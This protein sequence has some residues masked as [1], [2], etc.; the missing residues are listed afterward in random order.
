M[1]A[2]VLCG[3][4]DGAAVRYLWLIADLVELVPW[5]SVQEFAPWAACLYPSLPVS[6]LAYAFFFE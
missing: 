2:H 3:N 6:W 5:K 1:F 4:V